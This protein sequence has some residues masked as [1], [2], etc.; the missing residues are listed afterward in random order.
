M[1]CGIL[2]E[3]QK[4]LQRSCSLNNEKQTEDIVISTKKLTKVFEVP[5]NRKNSIK[6]VFLHPFSRTSHD[7]YVAFKNIDLDIKRGEFFG[8]VG[9]NGSGKST[10]LKILGGIYQPTSGNIEVKGSITTFIELGIGFNPELS[11]K[12]NVFLNGAI[13]GLTRKEVLSKYKEIVDFAELH[14]FMDQKLKNYSSGMQVRLAF[15]IAIQS[16]NE[17]LLI[18]EV[19]AVGDANFQRKC[20]DV[21]KQIRNSGKT[22]VFV[23]H[24]MNAVKEFCDR[25]VLIE[26]G[27]VI[28]EGVPSVV[29][30][31]YIDMFNESSENKINSKNRWG[32]HKVTI[33]KLNVSNSEEIVKISYEIT[34][35][36]QVEDPIFGMIVRDADNNNLI[37]SNTKWKSIKTGV[38]NKGERRKVQWEIPNILRTGTYTVSPAAAHQDGLAFYDWQDNAIKFNIVKKTETAGLILANHDMSVTKES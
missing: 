28:S 25:A 1:R 19:L 2:G 33:G 17:V 15:S 10:L 11:G 22:I 26:K 38:I 32:D 37:D 12:D 7:K 34:A 9:R 30:N 20:F 3:V 14:D 13:L 8:I 18:D 23:S 6:D 35:N 29:A 16:H 31:D 21:F 4:T 5:H 36:E 27:K 24:D